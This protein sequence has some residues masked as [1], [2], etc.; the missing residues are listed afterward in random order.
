MGEPTL[1]YEGATCFPDSK[2]GEELVA[3]RGEDS[4]DSGVKLVGGSRQGLR[5][6]LNRKMSRNE[7]GNVLS[8]TSLAEAEAEAE[9]EGS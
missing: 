7:K 2:R 4:V 1:H 5:R 3:R 9:G 8:R 6:M